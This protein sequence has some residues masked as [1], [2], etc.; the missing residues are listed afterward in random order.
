M[1]LGVFTI[2]GEAFFRKTTD[3]QNKTPSR[4]SGDST[5]ELTMKSANNAAAH[6]QVTK[7]GDLEE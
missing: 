7:M 4:K 6:T 1:E 2:L 3:S 5:A